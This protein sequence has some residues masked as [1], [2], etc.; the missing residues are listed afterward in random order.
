MMMM[1]VVVMMM[2]MI[3]MIMIMA[4]RLGSV[5]RVFEGVYAC[6]APSSKINTMVIYEHI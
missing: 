5:A 6:R 3:M 2:M 1:M 4:G